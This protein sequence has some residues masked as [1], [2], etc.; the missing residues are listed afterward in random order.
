VP[1]HDRKLRVS[2]I[3]V[4]DVQI[5]AANPAGRN[6]DQDLAG[7]GSLQRSLAHFEPRS[8]SIQHHGAHLC[9]R[10]PC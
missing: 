10:H 5:G 4:D 8:G 3:A 9:H 6:R 1:G 7:T 2:E